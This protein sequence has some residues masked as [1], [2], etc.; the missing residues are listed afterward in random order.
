MSRF[1][2]YYPFNIANISR[3]RE[4]KR[5]ENIKI[6]RLKLNLNNLAIICN[7]M[8][9]HDEFLEFLSSSLH[10]LFIFFE[11]FA[12]IGGLKRDYDV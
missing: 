12:C 5:D 2:I 6:E 7:T 9:F 3:E 8:C 1:I 11:R 4:K 10:F